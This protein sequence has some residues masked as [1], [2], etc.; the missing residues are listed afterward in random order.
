MPSRYGRPLRSA[1]PAAAGF[2]A[3]ATRTPMSAPAG[4]PPPRPPPPLAA[5]PESERAESMGIADADEL[6]LVHD[7]QGVRARNPRQ[8]A[9]QR[10]HEGAA[11]LPGPGRR[12][13]RR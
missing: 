12:H 7:H 3:S 8:E 6:P 5:P 4:R 9:D 2:P 1:K 11:R 10:G 13:A